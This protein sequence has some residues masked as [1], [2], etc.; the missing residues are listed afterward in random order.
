LQCRGQ[1]VLEVKFFVLQL[2]RYSI[3]HQKFAEKDLHC[4]IGE[5]ETGADP[6]AV[7]EGNVGVV[8]N[9]AD[10]FWA[11][12]IG[13]ELHRVIAPVGFIGVQLKRKE[14]DERALGNRV[15]S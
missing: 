13:F 8:M 1:P 15:R 14:E 11:E 6:W 2:R 7:G 3:L 5:L 4:H 10:V 12:A 9:F